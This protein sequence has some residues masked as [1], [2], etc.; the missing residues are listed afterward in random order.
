[1]EVFNK[2]C[3]TTLRNGGSCFRSGIGRFASADTIIPGPTNPQAHNRYSYVLGNPL[4]L[5]DPSGHGQ[6]DPDNNASCQ[7]IIEEPT[8]EEMMQKYG[9]EFT[10][11]AGEAWTDEQK[12]A[13]LIAVANVA[14]KFSLLKNFEGYT[15]DAAWG[16]VMGTTTMHR[17]SATSYTDSNGVTQ[18]IA[19]GGYTV[20]S[21][22]IEFYDTAFVSANGA[23]IRLD[24][25]FKNNVVHEIGHMFNADTVNDTKVS[26][27]K[28]LTTAIN[29]EIVPAG[30]SGMEPYPVSQSRVE[31]S[32]EIFADMFLSWVYNSYSPN[33]FGSTRYSW[34]DDRMTQWTRR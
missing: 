9:I 7:T 33:S 34:M 12:I 21:N 15:P 31:T 5:V 27:Y 29:D 3:R 6:C 19:H 14:S 8:I 24:P 32:N 16:A 28:N 23:H 13:V 30:R 11:D 18:T 22:K 25:N 4:R 26:P 10:A 20:D 17:S 2:L 1:M